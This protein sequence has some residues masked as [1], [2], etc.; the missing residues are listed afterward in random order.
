MKRKILLFLGFIVFMVSVR[1]Q[2]SGPR[3]ADKNIIIFNSYLI[4]LQSLPDSSYGY[5]ILYQS[6]PV[7]HQNK[8]PFTSLP[9]GFRNKEDAIKLAKWQAMQLMT[10]NKQ[11]F[12]NNPPVAPEVAKLLNITIN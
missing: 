12:L 2:R 7:V 10:S 4:H 6:R 8:N 9:T 5:D 11:Q 1:A 3:N